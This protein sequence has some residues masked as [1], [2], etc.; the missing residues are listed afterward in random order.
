[1]VG[2]IF[3]R[4]QKYLDALRLQKK[5]KEKKDASAVARARSPS[6][7]TNLKKLIKQLEKKGKAHG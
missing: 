4:Q 5:A 7:A 1:M 6:K 2:S 3:T